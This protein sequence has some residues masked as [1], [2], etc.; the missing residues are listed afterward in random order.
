MGEEAPYTYAVEVS[1]AFAPTKYCLPNE[2][3]N[4][5]KFDAYSLGC[6]FFN[7]ITG[8]YLSGWMSRNTVQYTKLKA[9]YGVL[10]ADLI[11]GL[12]HRDECIRLT[13][14]QALSHPLFKQ[15]SGT[16]WSYSHSSIASPLRKN[17]SI[18]LRNESSDTDLISENTSFDNLSLNIV[19]S[20]S[21]PRLCA[22]LNTF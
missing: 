19:S 10:I 2:K 16:R 11:S 4:A 18:L 17:N 12:T 5:E 8:Q 7:M 9:D 20:L 13:V 6:V 15:S 3:V 14:K 1:K 22:N 21:C